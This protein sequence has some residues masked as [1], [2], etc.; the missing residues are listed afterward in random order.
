MPLPRGSLVQIW[1]EIGSFFFFQNIMFTGLVTNE[2]KNGRTDRRTSGQVENILPL[3]ASL[4]WQR[5]KV[6]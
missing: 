6:L 4:V 5:H 2:R 3:P 1:N